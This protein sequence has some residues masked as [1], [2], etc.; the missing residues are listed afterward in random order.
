[1]ANKRLMVVCP[2]AKDCKKW[3]SH[4]HPHPEGGACYPSRSPADKE[5]AD[6]NCPDCVEVK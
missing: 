1:M 3:C 2:K 4:K 6:P 5:F